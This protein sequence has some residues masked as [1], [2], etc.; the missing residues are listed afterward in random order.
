MFKYFYCFFQCKSTLSSP[1]PSSPM[2]QKVSF[3]YQMPQTAIKSIRPH[4]FPPTSSMPHSARHPRFYPHFSSLN[5]S[6]LTMSSSYLLRVFYVFSTTFL[7][8]STDKTRRKYGENPMKIRRTY[9]EIAKE[10]RR[11]HEE[12]HEK[13]KHTLT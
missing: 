12:G 5:Y 6:H 10:E 4:A 11:G 7:R 8:I 3:M 1:S 9:V 13:S 2:I